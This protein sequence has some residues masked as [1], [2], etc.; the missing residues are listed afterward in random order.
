MWIKIKMRGKGRSE[1]R[2]QEGRGEER[3]R[4]RR[5][6]GRWEGREGREGGERRGEKTGSLL[7][8]TTLNQVLPQRPNTFSFLHFS[9]MEFQLILALTPDKMEPFFLSLTLLWLKSLASFP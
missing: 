6:E 2:G 3:G 8:R 4:K 7:V 9:P 1:R 5:G